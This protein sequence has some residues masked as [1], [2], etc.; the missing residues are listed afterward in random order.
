MTTSNTTFD[1]NEN[2]IV[3]GDL[4]LVTAA[5]G[6]SLRG[7]AVRGSDGVYSDV[8]TG[9][10]G[11]ANKQGGQGDVLIPFPGRIAQG[12]YE[13]D[14]E[15]HLM[16]MNDH[17]G[18]S[19]IHGFVRG[20]I[21][22]A[23]IK[24]DLVRYSTAINDSD[25]QG[26]PFALEIVV[27]YRLTGDGLA[28]ETRL[29]N[30]GDGDAPVAAGFH[31]YFTV[32]SDHIDADTLYVPF[33]KHLEFGDYFLPTGRVL[34]VAGTPLDFRSPRTIG[35]TPLNVCYL[36]PARDGDGKVRIRLTNPSGDRSVA[37]WLGDNYNYAVIY[38][39]DALPEEHR[40]RS[41]AIEAQTCASDAFNHPEWGLVRLAPGQTHTGTWGVEVGGAR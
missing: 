3:K 16:V 36:D 5:Y 30:V 24:D 11:R 7:L 33:S 13:F 31:P 34:D 26:Y 28:V 15:S 10:R 22:E 2:T 32:G 23:A 41:L 21:W 1:D 39:G 19:A 29:T 40:R 25:Y 12:R 17:E 18:P 37:V 35:A 38:S 8:I 14:G 6:A 4:R 9:Y 27:A 20:S